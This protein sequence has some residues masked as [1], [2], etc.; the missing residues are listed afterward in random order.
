MNNTR[1]HQEIRIHG[2]KIGMRKRRQVEYL[3]G[4]FLFSKIFVPN[5][6]NKKMT[7]HNA[8]YVY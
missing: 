4:F 7:S 8:T 5:Q 6:L 3:G 2:E 1:R